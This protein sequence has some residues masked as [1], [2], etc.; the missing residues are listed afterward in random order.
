[1]AKKAITLP[2]SPKLP[3]SP[4]IRA[5]DYIFVSGQVGHLDERGDRIEG[6]EAQARQCFENMKKVLA[7]GGASLEDVVKVTVFLDDERDFTHMNNVYRGYFNEILPARS[8]VVASPPMPGIL[9]E[10]DCIAYVPEK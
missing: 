1:M 3:Y 8:T 2:T 4:G 5:G 6:I 9:I 10:V 7:A